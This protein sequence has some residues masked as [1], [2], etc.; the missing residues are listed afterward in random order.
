M[1]ERFSQYRSDDPDVGPFDEN[2]ADYRGAPYTLRRRGRTEFYPENSVPSFLSDDNGE[3]DP[4]EYITPL[5]KKRRASIPS[6]ILAGVLA[7][8]AVAILF[9]VFSTDAT[10]HIVVTA[11][12]L[13]SAAF[14]APPAA[15]Q[16]DPSQ[17]TA[18]STQSKDNAQ[19]SAP[20]SQTPTSV[21]TVT[22]AAA[23]PTREEITMAY[24]SAPLPSRAP[25]E[26]KTLRDAIHRLD[27]NEIAS[28]LRRG[29]ALIASGD[30]A[31]ARLVLRRAADAGDAHAAMTLAETYDPA[32]LEKLGVHGLVPDVAMARDWYEKAKKFGAAEATQRLEILASKQH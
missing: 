10:R 15:T 32:I 16:S 28:L 30:L 21:R 20:A 29:D 11:K 5:R 1:V 31:A 14:L 27:S 18:R 23:A 25:P 17:L 4:S 22:T 2:T 3:A 24:Q 6:R 19:P 7:A 12:T 9:A 8:A 26:L 13:A